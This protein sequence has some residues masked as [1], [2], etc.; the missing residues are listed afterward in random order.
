MLN[1]LHLTLGDSA[2]GCLRV[3]IQ[4]HGMPGNVSSIRDDLS[5]GPLDDGIERLDYMRACYGEEG[6]WPTD[7]TDA[8]EPWH[9]VL[10]LI[11]REEPEAIIIWR[12]DNVSE[13]TFL[14]MA[15]WQLRQLL[16]PLFQVVITGADDIPYV[17]VRMP[18]ELA[19]MYPGH[20]ELSQSE[21][22]QLSEDFVRIRRETG[23]LRR[24]EN[25]RIIGVPLDRYDQFL[26][27]SCTSNWAPA[28][29]V[30][31]TAMSR[32]DRNNMMSDSFFFSRLR[33]LIDQGCFENDGRQNKLRDYAVRLAEG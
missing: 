31:G 18:A 16:T 3:A 29:R 27:E 30:V 22:K 15:C 14:A 19:E 33:L 13:V 32:C 10:E 24:W 4:S 28:A 26:K 23:L 6:N 2:A 9:E 11:T 12:G 20:R 25:G 5:H 8:F 17:A 1:P 7:V 21:R